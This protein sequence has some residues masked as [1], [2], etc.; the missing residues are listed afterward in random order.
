V[1]LFFFSHDGGNFNT[2]A[3]RT[4]ACDAQEVHAPCRVKALLAKVRV[5]FAVVKETARVQL[6]LVTEHGPPHFA[7][8]WFDRVVFLLFFL[9][10]LVFFLV[11]LLLIMAAVFSI[12]ILSVASRHIMVLAVERLARTGTS[13]STSTCLECVVVVRLHEPLYERG[14][15]C[16]PLVVWQ[17]FVARLVAVGRRRHTLGKAAVA[18]AAQ[19]TASHLHPAPGF[20]FFTTVAAA[21]ER[22][23]APVICLPTCTRVWQFYCIGRSPVAAHDGYRALPP[24]SRRHAPA[25]TVTCA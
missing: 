15:H 14:F 13:T 7:L 23:N 1:R 9:L 2:A 25:F 22:A 20:V 6:A 12:A 21:C 4:A 18:R 3:V 8:A 16:G 11:F 17:T 5:R 19:Q 24:A 10:L